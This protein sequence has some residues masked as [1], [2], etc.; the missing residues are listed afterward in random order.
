[1]KNTPF[2]LGAIA[3]LFSM[4]LYAQRF[5]TP[6][7]EYKANSDVAVTIEASYAEIEIIEWNKNKVEVQGI[8]EVQGLPEEEA[9]GLFNDWDI[10]AQATPDKISI[11]SVSSNFG[12]EYFFI[13]NDKYLG[14]VVVDIPHISGTIVDILDSVNFVL[15]E[16]EN[17]PDI[18]FNMPNSFPFNHDS[19]AFDFEE[20]QNSSEYLKQWQE[21]NKDDL[22]RLKEELKKNNA[23]NTI[24]MNQKEIQREIER[25]KLEVQKA[26]KEVRK[27]MIEAEV[28]VKREIEHHKAERK[29][30]IEIG[31]KEREYQVK[32]IMEKRHK[33]KVKKTIR[34]KVPK[35]ARLEMDVDYCKITTIN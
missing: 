30:M 29:K 21:R 20:F 15:P 32:K 33:V 7:Q 8:M 16:F 4:S 11:R 24:F 14:N 5:E 22:E 28:K 9:K 26:M 35:N 18:E 3:C 23:P 10:S 27:E 17:F 13:N 12:N 19:I 1:M 2:K 25:A 31:A 34:I 6:V